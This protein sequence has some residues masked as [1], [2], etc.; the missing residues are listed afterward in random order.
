[1]ADT[2]FVVNTPAG[3]FSTAVLRKE[4][5]LW[6]GF[7][8]G[9]DPVKNWDTRFAPGVGMVTEVMAIY[10]HAPDV[11]ERRLLRYHLAP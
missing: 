7:S 8:Q 5:T 1:M 9:T 2:G 6:P 3:I 10:S 4:Y 11:W